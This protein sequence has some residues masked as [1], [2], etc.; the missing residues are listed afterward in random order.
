MTVRILVIDDSAV[1]RRMLTDCLD[2]QPGFQVVGTAPDPFVARDQIV[3]LAP[4]V[5]TL[6]LDLPRMTGL[7]FLRILMPVHP[8]PTVVISEFT[9]LGSDQAQEAL[10]AGAIEVLDK[11]GLE[12]D[13]DIFQARLV[14]AV[15]AASLA[16][17]R[18]PRQSPVGRTGSEP[19]RR[20]G[21]EPARRPGSEPARRPGS[22]PAGRSASDR[23]TAVRSI[24]DRQAAVRSI[25]DRQTAVRALAPQATGT[26]VRPHSPLVAIGSS[27]GG[28]TA[29]E[30]ILTALPAGAPGVV[31]VQ[32]MPPRFTASLAQRLASLCAVEV[33]EAEQGDAIVPGRVLIAPGD[34][35]LVIER[36]GQGW[37]AGLEDG[38]RLGLHKPAVNRLFE[39]VAKA[40]GPHAIGVLLTGMGRDGADGMKLMHDAGASTIA[41]DEAT[42]VVFGMPMEAIKLGC[43]DRVLPIEAIAG[44]L[45]RQAGQRESGSR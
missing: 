20:P 26:A 5:L 24:S 40:A 15:R 43:V 32:H 21:S 39:S 44:E 41:Q 3:H 28:V 19:A 37:R 42:C 4:D 11:A 12:Q 31:I 10:A 30:T 13:A 23:Q 35:H 14:H 1:I 38:P 34:R 33:K 2:R 29:L 36:S 18:L 17:L 9:A 7:A 22:E 27:T 45:M 6:D 25:S 16:R 8:I